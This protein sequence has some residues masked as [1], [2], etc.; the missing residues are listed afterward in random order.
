MFSGFT[1]ATFVPNETKETLKH[2]L[3]QI[4]TPIRN[5]PEVIVRTDNAPAFTSL[6]NKPTATL[7]E[8]GLCIELV[9]EGNKN[10][11]AIV[12]KMI[13]ELEIEIK[14]LALG[15]DEISYGRA[16]DTP[17]QS[18]TPDYV[19]TSSSEIYFSRDLIRGIN[20]ILGDSKHAM[21]KRESRAK[22]KQLST[23]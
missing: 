21:E 5:S 1:T 19:K 12:D 7:Q 11:N 3:V 8:N 16:L 9:H 4:I 20:L 2:I 13:Q 17:L 23:T 22:K 15:G 18:S 6:A 10:S 14:K